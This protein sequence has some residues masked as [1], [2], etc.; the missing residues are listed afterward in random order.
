MDES[1]TVLI[2][3]SNLELS[4]QLLL[5]WFSPSASSIFWIKETN[6]QH[7]VPI[8]HNYLLETS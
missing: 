6:S 2:K 3:K 4:G 8:D 5:T 7:Q 1:P